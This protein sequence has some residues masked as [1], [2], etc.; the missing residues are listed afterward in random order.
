M[1]EH[2]TRRSSTYACSHPQVSLVSL[3][4]LV[5]RGSILPACAADW[6]DYVVVLSTFCSGDWLGDG[7]QVSCP[8][9]PRTT[10]LLCS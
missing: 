1:L 6:Y 4:S 3:V 10:S 7:E 9:H 2:F 8:Q 5:G